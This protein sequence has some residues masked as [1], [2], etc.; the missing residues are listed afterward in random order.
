MPTPLPPSFYDRD[1][2]ETAR[3]LLGMRLVRRLEDGTTLSGIITETEAYRGQDDQACHARNGRT[4]RN[5]VMFGPPGRAYIYFTYGMHWCLNV[6]AG[7]DG[8]P[9][10]VLLRAI[11]PLEGLDFIALRRARAE[12]RHW[13]NGPAKLTQALAIDGALNGCDLTD[14]ASPLCILPGTPPPAERITAGARVGLGA[15]PEPWLSMPWRFT[16]PLELEQ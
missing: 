8:F 13:T 12:R 16:F 1:V 14:P 4:R 3:A 10:A 7:P 11:H 15:T 6:V 5:A 9:A 2:V